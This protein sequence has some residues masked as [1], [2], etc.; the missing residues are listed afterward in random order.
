MTNQE[1]RTMR[2]GD[3]VVGPDGKTGR[4]IA[5]DLPLLSVMKPNGEQA[6][7]FVS[8]CRRASEKTQ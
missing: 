1:A 8:H 4:L 3:P 2:F 6:G 5:V 7:W